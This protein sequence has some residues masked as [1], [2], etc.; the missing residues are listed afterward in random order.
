M[1]SGNRVNILQTTLCISAGADAVSHGVAAA[2]GFALGAALSQHPAARL[3][4]IVEEL[5]FN[6]IDHAG[7]AEGAAIEMTL[8]LDAGTIRLTLI[9]PAPPF[10]PRLML[11]PDALPPER[12][13]GAG[14]AMLRAWAQVERYDRD[15][16]RNIL[17][18]SL[19][20]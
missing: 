12:G 15:G 6:L 3:A 11:A 14:L 7:L 10:D 9:D 1:D 20:G 18:L 17:V 16:D 19:P 2:R 13:G 5:L 4:I 8:V